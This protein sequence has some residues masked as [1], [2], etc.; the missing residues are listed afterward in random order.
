VTLAVELG[1]PREVWLGRAALGRVLDRLGRDRDAGAQLAQ[2]A[3]TIAG[4][5]ETLT[6]AS[7]RWSFLGA[8]P[9]VEVY[10][11]RNR[12]PPASGSPG[13][14]LGASSVAKR[15]WHSRVTT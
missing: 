8:E 4:I 1:T 2:A 14:P 7:L 5:A 6:T 13:L 3:D 9:V 10:R 11:A 15:F 12:R